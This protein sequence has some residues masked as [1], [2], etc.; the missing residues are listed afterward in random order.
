MPG[1][2][3]GV[4]AGGSTTR[5]LLATAEG[6]VIGAGRAA[7]ANMW[8]SGKSVSG[9]LGLAIRHALQGSM[10]ARSREA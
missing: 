1:L 9:S 10:Q 4:D 3:L 2:Y 8:S 5:A 7:G 6:A